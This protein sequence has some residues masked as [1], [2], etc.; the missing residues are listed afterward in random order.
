MTDK[1]ISAKE[2]R[3]IA[4]EKTD[5]VVLECIKTAYS[6][7]KFERCFYDIDPETMQLLLDNG[8]KVEEI[9]P[10]EDYTS[11]FPG[12]SAYFLVSW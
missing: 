12:A 4:S 1:I 10:T 3:K 2:A 7:N 11:Q 9:K 8:Y 6:S 5:N